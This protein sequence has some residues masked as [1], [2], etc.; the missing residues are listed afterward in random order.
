MYSVRFNQI[1]PDIKGIYNVN[2]IPEL[3]FQDER[4][5]YTSRLLL[6]QHGNGV[7]KFQNNT[8]HIR[9]GCVLYIPAM[10]RYMT[11]IHEELNIVHLCFDFVPCHTATEIRLQPVLND[12][13]LNSELLRDSI[14]IEDAPVFQTAF[15]MEDFPNIVDITVQLLKEYNNRLHGYTLRC[16]AMLMDM[17]VTLLRM[18][19]SP[20]HTQVRLAATEDILEYIRNN[21][22][23]ALDRKELSRIFH[24]HPNHINRL[25]QQA[26]GMTLHQFILHTRIH[27]AQILLAS[28]ALPI[29]QIA[30][31]L[32]F[33]DSS[34]FSAVFQKYSGMIPSEYRKISQKM[35]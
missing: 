24:Y 34:H 32:S 6:F 19:I 25:V 12:A 8:Y 20:D 15:M 29:T 11:A 13:M 1:N 14:Q 17:L 26:T 27:R 31:Q 30:Q 2:V 9:P 28:T 10:E 18:A 35:Y 16:R 21:C 7:F 33:Y 23:S 3:C 22:D 5:F 4:Y